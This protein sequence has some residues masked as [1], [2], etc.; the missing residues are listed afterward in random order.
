METGFP[1]RLLPDSELT[2]GPAA[3]SL[4]SP[5]GRCVPAVLWRVCNGVSWVC[6]PAEAARPG[7]QAS[8]L[9]A[10]QSLQSSTW[11]IRS[12]AREYECRWKRKE[13]IRHTPGSSTSSEDLQGLKV[14]AGAGATRHPGPRCSRKGPGSQKPACAPLGSPLDFCCYRSLDSPP[15]QTCPH[16]PAPAWARCRVPVHRFVG[17]S[18]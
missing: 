3:A 15:P 8:C 2:Q 11:E 10:L 1:G 7:A 5:W 6:G 13:K 14:S 16:G 17:I 12:A 9:A 4:C 18:E